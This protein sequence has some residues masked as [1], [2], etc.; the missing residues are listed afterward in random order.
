MRSLYVGMLLSLIGILAVSLLAF[1][2]ISNQIEHK[3]L[4]PVFEATDELQLESARSALETGGTAALS[5]YLEKLNQMFQSSA[6][7]LLN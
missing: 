4:D 1:L 2:M 6:H 5:S 3:Y 7:F